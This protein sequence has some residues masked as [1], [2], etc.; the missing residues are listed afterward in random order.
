MA[1]SET[2][3]QLEALGS[4][5]SLRLLEGR[6]MGRIG[7][8]VRGRPLI[9]PINYV[10]LDNGILFRTRR[11]GDIHQFMCTAAVAFE[12]D[13]SDTTYHEGW[14]VVVVRPMCRSD[15]PGRARSTRSDS[16]AALGGR[17]S[18]SPSSHLHRG[19]LRSTHRPSWDLIRRHD[20]HNDAF[21]GRAPL[22]GTFGPTPLS[23]AG[24]Q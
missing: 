24:I 5:E 7:G 22:S 18:R 3:E 4:E 11:G 20:A 19:D 14:S 17:A 6:G 8:I 21:A 23:S 12:V 16:S 10:V 13:E 1:R 2:Y 9:L 15:R